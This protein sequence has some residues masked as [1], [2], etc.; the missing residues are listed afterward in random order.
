MG[1]S[2]KQ[3]RTAV[4]VASLGL[5]ALGCG[6]VRL[7]PVL[8]ATLPS[9]D[10]LLAELETR[11]TAV[12]SLRGFAQIAYESADDTLGSRHAV[13]AERPDRFRLEVLS[14]FGTLALVANNGPELV[15]Y[16]RR[17]SA[18]YRGVTTPLNI[19]AYTGVPLA[20]ADVVAILLGAPPERPST[21]DSIVLRDEAAG[22][23]RLAVP[24]AEGTQDIWFEPD[25]LHPVVSLTPLADGRALKVSFGNYEARGPVTFPFTIDI[26]TE[27]RAGAVHVRYTSPSLNAEIIEHMFGFKPRQGVEERRIDQ[28]QP[29]ETA[30]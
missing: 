20:A 18:V 2:L 8:P 28:Y 3:L 30:S 23:I 26:E 29:A 24:V 22:L 19:A 9:A 1:P 5:V 7:R 25:T 12:G 15:V 11:R 14:A 16:V 27:P 10:R 21:G 13:L 4:C 6:T 17:D